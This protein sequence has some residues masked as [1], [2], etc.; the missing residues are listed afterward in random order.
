MYGD[1]AKL[2]AELLA[3]VLEASDAFHNASGAAKAAARQRY[4][5]LLGAFNDFVFDGCHSWAT[6]RDLADFAA[7]NSCA[8]ERVS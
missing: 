6:L 5:E 7:Q 2:E 3:Q 1:R 4:A 8:A